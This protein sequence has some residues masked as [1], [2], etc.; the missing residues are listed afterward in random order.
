MR[1]RPAP[2]DTRRGLTALAVTIHQQLRLPQLDDPPWS[3]TLSASKQSPRQP[4]ASDQI[5]VEALDMVGIRDPESR[6][7]SIRISSPAVCASA[8]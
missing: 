8:S 6:L 1:R 2:R 7:R 5:A 3:T 4:R